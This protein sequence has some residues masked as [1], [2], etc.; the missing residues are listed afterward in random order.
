MLGLDSAPIL[1]SQF[2]DYPHFAPGAAP[3]P[4]LRDHRWTPT[5]RKARN[6]RH[7][8]CNTLQHSFATHLNDYDIRPAREL[9]GPEDVKTIMAY[10]YVLNR[11]GR[12]VRNPMDALR[13]QEDRGVS[14][15]NH[16]IQN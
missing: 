2:K 9:V 5:V 3:N 16:I 6:A 4:K 1:S 13:V 10:T 15:G 12:G 14:C 11:V 7:L 8:G